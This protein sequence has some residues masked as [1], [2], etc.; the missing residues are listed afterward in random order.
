VGPPRDL[1][2]ANEANPGG[3]WESSSLAV[4]NDGILD[5]WDST[6]WTPPAEVSSEMIA[7]LREWEP[8]ASSSFERSF[9][10]GPGWVWKDP[11]LTVLLG[12]WTLLLGAQPMLVLVRRPQGVTASIAARDRIPYDRALGIWGRHTR[13]LI[14]SIEGPTILLLE[15]A[16]LLRE[17]D[18]WLGALFDF[19]R[20]AGLPVSWPS[21]QPGETVDRSRP[22]PTARCRIAGSSCSPSFAA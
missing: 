15:Y 5:T 19:C 12:F 16:D 18:A 4:L 20:A 21:T 6:W 2:P 9:G 3:Y 7:R 22:E 8:E 10:A 1:V 13:N 17:P 14:R 11:R